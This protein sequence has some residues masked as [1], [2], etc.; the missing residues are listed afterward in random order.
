[1]D[2]AA[3]PL[4]TYVGEILKEVVKAPIIIEGKISP[5]KLQKPR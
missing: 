2:T 5:E 3:P 4:V 1:M